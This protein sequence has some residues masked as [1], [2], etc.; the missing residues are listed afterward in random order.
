V[1]YLYER[2]PGYEIAC[3]VIQGDWT[4][5]NDFLKKFNCTVLNEL[6]TYLLDVKTLSKLDN[7]AYTTRIGSP[8]D[9]DALF[10]LCLSEPGFI[11]TFG[12][13]EGVKTFAKDA[14]KDLDV[15]LIYKGDELVS[16]GAVFTYEPD[17]EGVIGTR[18]TA[19]KDYTF[20][21]WKACAIALAKRLEEKGLADKKFTLFDR[22]PEHLKFY[23]EN[24]TGSRTGITYAVPKP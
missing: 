18:F 7:S 21:N 12:N 24:A 20:V 23:E 2:D 3:G 8:D 13:E 22:T 10:K 19:T 9:A 11:D 6:N 1:N 4:E 15:V 17:N 14:L 16:A 5:I